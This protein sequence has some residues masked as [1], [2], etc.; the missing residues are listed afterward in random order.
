MHHSALLY[1]AF[2]FALTACA[3]THRAVA[4]PVVTRGPYLQLSKPKSIIVRWRTNE[5]T[6]SRVLYGGALGRMNHITGDS[7]VTTEHEVKLKDLRPNKPYFY[8]VGTSVQTL[9]S[10]DGFSFT[11]PPAFGTADPA[12]VWVL[13]DSGTANAGAAA[14]RDGYASFKGARYTDLILMLGDNAYENGT[15]AEFQAAVFDMYPGFLRQSPLFPGLGNHDVS[16][17]EPPYFSIFD[18]PTNGH[19]NSKPSRTENYYSFDFANI[20]FV[21]LDSE[22][23]S[24]A[25][26]GPMANWLRKD[27][28]RTPRSWIV[29]YW[30][31]PPY[32]KSGD[33]DAGAESTDMRA[34]FGPILE[35]GGVDLVLAGHSHVY[36]R[37][38]L[39]NG[40]YGTSGTFQ[41]GMKL[42]ADDGREAGN[43]AYTKP[44]ARTPHSGTVYV[45]AG[46][47]GKLGSWS[48]GST[49][50]V[51]PNP[52]PA[53]FS[54]L[55]QLG[56]L[57]LDVNGP[58]MDV[59]FVRETGAVDDHFTIL[60][61][62]P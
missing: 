32:S 18:L 44:L 31:H 5:P 6:D 56:S 30:H 39:I 60:K 28:A 20:H 40:H 13:G 55:R 33:S 38:F 29:A 58:R 54:S 41:P 34:T 59:R 9:A 51:N 26:D 11:T 8:A 35:T 15:D 23:S 7:A 17:T 37:S 57:A 22:S 61:T 62:T 43:G 53:M 49:A 3:L 21:C 42:D 19:G 12:H 36:E 14:V 47:S 25:P 50:P 16:G 24:R 48:G 52:H 1:V 27:L 46:S 4:E 45:V 10:G 2:R